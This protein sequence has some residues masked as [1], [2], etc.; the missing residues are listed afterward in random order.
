MDA[1]REQLGQKW[2]LAGLAVVLGIVLGLGYGWGIDPVEWKDATPA[3]LR[4]DLQ[5]DYL[6]MAI[7]SYSANRDADVAVSRYERLGE[8]GP[9]I[10]RLV[11]E[12]PAEVD[13]TAIQNFSAVVEIMEESNQQ[14][15]DATPVE[16]SVE[17][18]KI[19]PAATETTSAEPSAM[20]MILPVCG[21]TLLLGL[22]LIG[23]LYL[24]NRLGGEV[25]DEPF[26]EPGFDMPDEYESDMQDR[27]VS[28]F[29]EP[30]VPEPEP[31]RQQS[32]AVASDV[33][34]LSTFRTIYAL[35]DDRYDDSFSVES[36]SGDFIGECGVGI[37][38][39]MG[40]GEPKKVSAFEVWL[41]D[42]NDIQTVT[43]VLMSEYT[44]KDE[45]TRNRMAAKGDPVLAEPGGVIYL[46]TA[47][48]QVEARI[49][50]MTYG[51]SALPDDSF[52]ERMTIELRAAAK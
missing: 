43:K 44:Y 5:V 21:A 47:A 10:L 8:A 37:G 18:T 32:E 49:V 29:G 16:E 51:Q 41:F 42:K 23:A 22:L 52:F 39:V 17:P 7:D 6:R 40:A 14:A 50:D 20:R 36:A 31:P 48:L 13:P 45:E 25:E 11:G 30:E 27:L 4:Q 19:G 2:V 28:E 34:P 38:E 26:L 15:V 46:E 24:R 3:L 35:G 12:S 1:I 33:E 9:E